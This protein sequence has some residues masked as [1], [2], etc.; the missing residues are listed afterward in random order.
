MTQCMV[1]TGAVLN[2]RN[3]S[4]Y[5]AIAKRY[6]HCMIKVFLTGLFTNHSFGCEWWWSAGNQD[7]SICCCSVSSPLPHLWLEHNLHYHHNRPSSQFESNNWSI[8]HKSNRHD[9]W[10]CWQ[11][12]QGKAFGLRALPHWILLHNKKCTSHCQWLC[13]HFLCQIFH[14]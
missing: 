10:Y 8:V 3:Y 4:F 14:H 9:N 1:N 11:C 2:T 5:A 6:L 7:R 12:C 13:C